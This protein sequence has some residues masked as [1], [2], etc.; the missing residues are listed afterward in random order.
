MVLEMGQRTGVSAIVLAAGL[1]RRMGTA[2]PLVDVGG[3]PM[4]A[5]VLRTVRESQVDEVIVVLGHAAESIQQAVPLVGVKVVVNDAYA[6]GMASSI[7]AGLAHVAEDSEAALVVL[8]DQPFLRPQTIDVLIEQYRSGKPE[9]VI[10]VC[11]G[12]RGNP[13]LLDRAL[14]AEA[15]ALSGDSGFRAIFGTHADGILKVPVNDQGVLTDLDTPHDIERY[16]E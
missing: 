11:E 9:I 12:L 16:R 15:A 5:R 6:S 13:V 4:L 8:G 10:P 2:K 7:R 14:F 1:S 3:E